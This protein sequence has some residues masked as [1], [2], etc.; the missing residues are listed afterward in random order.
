MSEVVSVVS[1]RRD[2]ADD[3]ETD[4]QR[5][6]CFSGSVYAYHVHS[7]YRARQR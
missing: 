2:D 4:A 1:A 6:E 5:W 3:V 7:A